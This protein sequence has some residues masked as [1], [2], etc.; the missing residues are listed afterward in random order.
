MECLGVEHFEL[1]QNHPFE[2]LA[3]E[4]VLDWRDAQQEVVDD[5]W[6]CEAV[7]GSQPQEED[8]T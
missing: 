1:Y 2:V 3:A 6:R 5:L 8:P 4:E 7:Q